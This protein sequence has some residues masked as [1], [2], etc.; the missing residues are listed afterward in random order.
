MPFAAILHNTSTNHRAFFEIFGVGGVDLIQ[1]ASTF[2]RNVS[3]LCVPGWVTK[4]GQVEPISGRTFIFA[5]RNPAVFLSPHVRMRTCLKGHWSERRGVNRRSIRLDPIFFLPMNFHTHTFLS[6]THMAP[7]GSG[8]ARPS[9]V[10]R[11]AA[12]VVA[13]VAL[14]PGAAGCERPAPS[15]KLHP[16]ACIFTQTST[17]C[18]R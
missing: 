15:P 2:Q 4:T 5:S 17:S 14:L 18:E 11:A 8:M 10:A 3:T 1:Q 13:L 6:N 7:H 9:A 16:A 12:V